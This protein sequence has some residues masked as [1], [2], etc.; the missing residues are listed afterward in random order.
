MTP[1]PVQSR[2]GLRA[3]A[4]VWAGELGAAEAP[5]RLTSTP[6]GA[7][8]VTVGDVV[9]KVHRTGTD[10]AA[11]GTRLVAA[12]CLGAPP[13]WVAPLA[14]EPRRTPDGR[15]ATVWPRVEVLA[16]SSANVP[17]S[18]AGAVLARWHT[19]DLAAPDARMPAHGGPDRLGRALARARLL[20]HRAGRLLVGLGDR[21]VREVQGAGRPV[22]TTDGDV[23]GVAPDL[24]GSLLRPH[25]VHGD[26]HLGQLGRGDGAW[27]LLDVD[28]LGVGDPAWDLGRPAGFWA[29][30][31]LDDLS[32]H[33]FLDGYRQAAG[34]AVPPTGDPWP[35]LDLAA[36]CAVFV[37]AVR[38]LVRG[39]A[40]PAPDGTARS[41]DSADLRSLLTACARM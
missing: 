2:P 27:R 22:A 26:W 23:A 28:D 32:W 1:R 8:L 19:T 15:W 35:Y 18:Q 34:P 3:W 31:L 11:L 20:D 30:G 14:L 10:A 9:V 33:S 29:A 38:E 41:P 12:A 5:T 25:L 40:G 4:T 13:V 37:A 6:S 16:P 24:G 17:W 36:R 39:S 21:L 7:E